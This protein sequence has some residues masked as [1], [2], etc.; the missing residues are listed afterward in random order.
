MKLKSN[1][2]NY[3][4]NNLNGLISLRGYLRV[5]FHPGMKSSLSMVKCLLCF[6]P[7]TAMTFIVLGDEIW[8]SQIHRPKFIARAF[9]PI[10][11]IQF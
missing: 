7:T 6:V 11:H 8:S 5:K 10:A 4:Q 3:F 1:I 9:P 2:K